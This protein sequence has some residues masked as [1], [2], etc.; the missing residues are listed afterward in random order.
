MFGIADFCAFVV[1]FGVRWF[2]RQMPIPNMFHV[3][4]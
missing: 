1:A 3:K 4:Q 2:A